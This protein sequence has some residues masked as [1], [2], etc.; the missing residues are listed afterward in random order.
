MQ[1][2]SDTG[3]LR[4]EEGDLGQGLFFPWWWGCPHTR[5]R[6]SSLRL[7]L[8]QVGVRIVTL[9]LPTLADRR[10]PALTGVGEEGSWGR[11]GPSRGLR[12][13]DHLLWGSRVWSS[14]LGN[15]RRYGASL[16]LGNAYDLAQNGGGR[17]GMT[18]P[19]FVRESGTRANAVALASPTLK[20]PLKPGKEGEQGGAAERCHR[21]LAGAVSPDLLAIRTRRGRAGAE[22]SSPLINQ[23]APHMTQLWGPSGQRVGARGHGALGTGP[24][25]SP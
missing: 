5:S 9:T 17:S 24:P 25:G 12:D 15:Q 11:S 20:K 4:E 2:R 19:T 14:E 23:F 10:S 3:T 21:S 7:E 22:T 18:G 8:S 1:C 13:A 16:P 6:R